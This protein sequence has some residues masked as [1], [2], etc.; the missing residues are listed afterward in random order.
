MK[1]VI[2]TYKFSIGF[3]DSF[4]RHRQASKAMPAATNSVYHDW[5]FI[6]VNSLV[7]IEVEQ[8]KYKPNLLI[9]VCVTNNRHA[10]KNFVDAD[11]ICVPLLQFV[12]SPESLHYSHCA[13]I[14]GGL[15]KAG[16]S[17]NY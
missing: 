12:L 10:T 17:P 1:L 8:S 4:M 2:F 15:S 14:W 6:D 11:F 3:Q 13:Q 16:M 5:Y 7:P 9:V